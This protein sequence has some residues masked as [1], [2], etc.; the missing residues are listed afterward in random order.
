MLDCCVIMFEGSECWDK[1]VD[2]YCIQSQK[3][4]GPKPQN[5]NTLVKADGRNSDFKCTLYLSGFW[6]WAENIA[7]CNKQ[8]FIKYQLILAVAFLGS[9]LI[10][11]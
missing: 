6:W 10:L 7:S 4:E 3:V 1:L 9:K 11:V 2:I 5:P 8:L